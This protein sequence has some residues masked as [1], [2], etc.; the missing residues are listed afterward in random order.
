MK[1][2]FL[3][4]SWL[5][6]TAVAANAQAKD[7]PKKDSKQSG[8]S[9]TDSSYKQNG[10]GT[11]GYLKDLDLTKDQEKQISELHKEARDEREKINKDSTLSDEQKKDKIKALEKEYK[12]KTNSVLTKEQRDKL[13][14]K[15][16]AGKNKEADNTKGK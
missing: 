12:G 2:T 9:A 11:K 4:I 13:K 14:E 16:E 6:V 3:L 5:L 7:S 8:L 1:H 15:K 10:K